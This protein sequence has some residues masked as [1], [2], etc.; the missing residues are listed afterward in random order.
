MARRVLAGLGVSPGVASGCA[1]ALDH[2]A[3]DGI[4]RI[5]LSPETVEAEC[6]RLRR[7][8][9]RAREDLSALREETRA[10]LAGDLQAIFEAQALLLEDEALLGRIERWIREHKVNAEWAVHRVEQDL[11]RQ[12]DRLEAPHL[13]ER[14]DDLRDVAR[15]L[16]RALE[17]LGCHQLSEVGEKVILVAHDLTPSEV[18]RLG[19]QEVAG[20]AL[21]T[22]GPTSHTAII[23]RS[24]HLPLVTGL[25]GLRDLPLGDRRL[26]VDGDRG[27]LVVEPSPAELEQE[28]TRRRA[29]DRHARDLAATRALAA[30]TLDGV[31]VE[32]AANIDL[33][34]EID[35]ARRVG[36]A[37][38]GLYRSEFLFIE[39]S[40]ELPTEDEQVA[41]LRRLVEGARPHAAVVRTFDLGGRKLAREVMH[42]D[43]ENPVLG[44]RGIRLTL[45]RPEVFR[46]Q[47]R[48]LLRVA[49]EGDLKV[50]LPMVA[51][52]EEVRSFRERLA[53]AASELAAAGVRHRADVPLGVMVEVPA[54]ALI[55]DRLAR[56]VDFFAIG[57]NDLI[58]YALAVDRNNEHVSY[59]YQPLHPAILRMLRS[60]VDGARGA[61]ID[62]SLCGE[63]AADPVLTPLL[64][65]LGLRRL[66]M[67][68]GALPEVK[69]RVR[70]LEAARLTALADR[71]LEAASAR[72]VE[73]LLAAEVA[74]AP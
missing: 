24:L 28:R 43:E 14:A 64:L 8:V 65:G 4:L 41:V 48:A 26:L 5:P 13:R 25:A 52:V 66:S 67:R 18:L 42:T 55:A 54:A 34:E 53:E 58:Q 59:L 3:A 40:P 27:L 35:E 57:S 51:A 23:A 70:S 22:G 7:A 74:V 69:A 11:A 49:A 10:E 50:L 38:V 62:V 29:E 72:E 6:A 20:F 17:G 46:Y 73:E 33:P 19:R 60:V 21:E 61:G 31:A 45:A 71:C 12:F 9:A 63:M 44:L 32:L 37:G 68:P 30:V 39:K 2:E 1:V 56:N 47:L 16:R 36:A 15:H